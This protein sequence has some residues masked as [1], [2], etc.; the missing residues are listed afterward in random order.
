MSFIKNKELPMAICSILA[1]ILVVTYFF[2]LPTSINEIV[3]EIQVWSMTVAS[4]ALGL[5]LFNLTRLHL[6]NIQRREKG[7]WY[8]SAWLLFIM[9]AMVVIGVAFTIKDPNYSWLYNNM[10]LPLGSTMYAITGFFVISAS[11]RAY[12][13][14]NL[15]SIMM[16]IPAICVMLLNA[17]FGSLIWPGFPVLGKWFMD[18]ISTSGFRGITITAY[19]IGSAILGIRVILWMEKGVVVPET[20]LEERK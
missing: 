12:R 6:R 2:E 8:F 19:G 3:E 5:G 4:I 11:Y 16:T 14:R 13:V 1:I 20:E 15:E 18:I 7:M 9:Y 17:P 10:Y